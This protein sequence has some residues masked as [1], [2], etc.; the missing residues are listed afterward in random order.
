MRI[1][2]NLPRDTGISS[3]AISGTYLSP[4]IDLGINWKTIAIIF[5]GFL[6]SSTAFGLRTICENSADGAF[7]L[8]DSNLGNVIDSTSNSFASSSYCNCKVY[9]T[10][11]YIKFHFTNGT[12]AAQSVNSYITPCLISL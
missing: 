3:L 10:G 2:R 4:V 6:T 5:H 11:R 7:S 1:I 9:P 8:T 12:T